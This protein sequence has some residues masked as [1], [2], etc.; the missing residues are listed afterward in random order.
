M[1][2]RG[3]TLL[4]LV[5]SVAVLGIIAGVTVAALPVGHTAS[6]DAW[7]LRATRAALRAGGWVEAWPDSTGS[8]P[9]QGCPTDTAT[10][11]WDGR[12]FG[13]SPTGA[14]VPLPSG[15]EAGP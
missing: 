14:P 11:H 12:R 7:C 2:R 3:M 15:K 13:Y 4:E 6:S 9:V 5:V 1:T 10:F 8:G